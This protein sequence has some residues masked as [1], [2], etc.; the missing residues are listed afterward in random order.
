MKIGSIDSIAGNFCLIVFAVWSLKNF[1][2]S[3]EI[4]RPVPEI[5]DDEGSDSSDQTVGYGVGQRHQNQ[6]H[7]R[8]N[9]LFHIIPFDLQ[10]SSHHQN[11]DENQRRPHGPR[12]DGSQQR[13][14]EDGQEEEPCYGQ[15]R[16]SSTAAFADS[17]G[18]FDERRHWRGAEEGAED[19]GGGVGHE[20]RVL[21]LEVAVL[22][23]EAGEAGHG[24]E[25]SGGVEDVDVEEGDEGFPEMACVYVLEAESAGGALNVVESDDFFE[26]IVGRIAG[27]GVGKCSDGGVAEP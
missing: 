16:H 6:R 4:R 3:Q 8:R 19:D 17:G 11:S 18:G 25:G 2:F 1:K 5:E 14:E 21:A 24:V 13:R 20:G 23:D 10:N 12:R 7:K 15:R 9:C 22:V 27:G 26:V